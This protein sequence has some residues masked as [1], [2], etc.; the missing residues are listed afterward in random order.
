MALL[1][2]P[3]LSQFLDP[4]LLLFGVQLHFWCMMKGPCA[5]MRLFKLLP[6]SD[7]FYWVCL[8]FYPFLRV[9]L[10]SL[11]S[12]GL[13]LSKHSSTGESNLWKYLASWILTP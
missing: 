7:P 3:N 6:F 2:I 5:F 13:R 4:D 9:R 11:E 10:R 1:F 8:S 12:A